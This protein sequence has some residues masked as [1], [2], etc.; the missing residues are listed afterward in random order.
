M[1]ILVTGGVGFVGSHIVERLIE[2]GENVFVFDVFNNE[3]TKASEK[4]DN[5]TYLE[6]KFKL[7]KEKGGS[8]VMIKGDLTKYDSI[9]SAIKENKISR[10]IHVAG[11][12]DDRRS[13]MFPMEY[14]DVNIK[15]VINLLKACGEC[16]VQHVIQTSTRSCFG[17]FDSPNTMLYED[18]PRHPIN[19]YGATKVASDAFGHV[20]HTIYPEMKVSIIRIF[21]TYGPRGRPDMIPRICVERI[22]KG[23]AIQKFG[24]GEATRVWIYVSDIV[25]AYMLTLDNPPRS[26]FEEYNTGHHVATTLNDMIAMAEKL[27]GKKAIIEQKPVPKGDASYVGKSCYDKIKAEL[28]WEPKV[29]LEEGLSLTLKYWLES[30]E[31][32]PI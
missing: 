16:K 18:S 13:V 4:N 32:V 31:R 22:Y 30:E 20:Y 23:E 26:G 25:D 15:G 9:Y 6:N 29:S 7:Y 5:K 14:V 17:Q 19:P 3:T 24:T 10:V 2:R 21:A 28:G 8:L 27:I 11:M 1:N 12:V